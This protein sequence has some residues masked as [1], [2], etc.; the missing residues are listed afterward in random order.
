[1]ADT[2]KE[3]A[4]RLQRERAERAAWRRNTGANG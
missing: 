3:L 2:L 1:M 4:E